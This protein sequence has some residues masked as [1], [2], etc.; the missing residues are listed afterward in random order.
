MTSA[1]CWMMP[2]SSGNAPPDSDVP[3]PRGT[4]G[5]ARLLVVNQLTAARVRSPNCDVLTT[6]VFVGQDADADGPARPPAVVRD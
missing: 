6:L 4:T 5:Y 2:S 1:A 3:A